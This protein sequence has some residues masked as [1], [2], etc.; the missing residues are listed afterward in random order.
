MSRIPDREIFKLWEEREQ[1][2]KRIEKLKK[3]Q[4]RRD[5]KILDEFKARGIRSIVRRRDG[6][7]VSMVA[8]EPVVYHESALRRRLSRSP[9]GRAII[10]RC[11]VTMLDMKAIAGEVLAGH[12]SKDI[13]KDCSEIK[14]S[15]PYLR[16]GEGDG[17]R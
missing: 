14:P 13:A 6:L 1:I 5:D 11:E 4:R 7:R 17:E 15:T 16:G 3:M 10:K 2:R 12:I 8:P 9:K